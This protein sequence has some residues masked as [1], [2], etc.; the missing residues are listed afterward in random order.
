[1]ACGTNKKNARPKQ[2]QN[3]SATRGSPKGSGGF[4]LPK[5]A[6]KPRIALPYL[7]HRT[8]QVT[9]IADTRSLPKSFNRKWRESAYRAIG[10]LVCREFIGWVET[11]SHGWF[12]S[13]E[14]LPGQRK[15]KSNASVKTQ[16]RDSAK[17]AVGC[18][19]VNRGSFFVL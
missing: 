11:Y 3:A 14:L 19:S 16:N 2:Q 9:K 17:L 7:T 18:N 12:G 10:A 5:R 4:L 1:M 13:A 8:C 15:T 6:V